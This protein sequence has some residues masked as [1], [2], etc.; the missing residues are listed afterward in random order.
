[1][2]L[3]LPSCTDH[4]DVNALE[5]VN[6][7]QLMYASK[8]TH[9]IRDLAA[10]GTQPETNLHKEAATCSKARSSQVQNGGEYGKHLVTPPVEWSADIDSNRQPLAAT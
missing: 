2:H 7:P 3:H 8:R 1:M 6:K 10:P 5:A 9:G 4:S